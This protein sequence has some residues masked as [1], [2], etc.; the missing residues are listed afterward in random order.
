MRNHKVS[1]L[2]QMRRMELRATHPRTWGVQ[3]GQSSLL[4]SSDGVSNARVKATG[5]GRTKRWLLLL[6]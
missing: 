2:M 3:H 1:L 4:H 5:G 6:G